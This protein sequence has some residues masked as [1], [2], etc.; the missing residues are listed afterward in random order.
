MKFVFEKAKSEDAK[1]VFALVNERIS[2]MDEIGVEQWNK[3]DYWMVYPQSYYLNAISNGR[4]FVLRDKTSGLVISAG[5][6]SESDSR[7]SDDGVK[8]VYLHNFVSSL[9]SPGSGGI[10]LAECESYAK[11][12]GAQVLRLDCAA[13]NDKLNDYYEQRGYYAVGVVTDGNYTGIKREKR[14]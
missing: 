3:E 9:V 12:Y 1:A 2:W 4:L 7:W 13:S 5:V 14:L 6:L 11:Q 8:A 10:F